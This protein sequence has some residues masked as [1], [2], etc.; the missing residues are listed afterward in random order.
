MKQKKRMY[1]STVTRCYTHPPHIPCVMSR[2][3]VARERL[4]HVARAARARTV[5]AAALALASTSKGSHAFL[6]TAATC[7]RMAPTICSAPIPADAV[8]W[9]H[10]PATGFYKNGMASVARVRGL[11]NV[12]RHEVIVEVTVTHAD[13]TVHGVPHVRCWLP[14]RDGLELVYTVTAYAAMR[15][16]VNLRARDAHL[17]CAFE[18]IPPVTRMWSE[19]P[20]MSD[21][22]F[23]TDR[24]AVCLLDIRWTFHRLDTPGEVLMRL[25]PC[26]VWLTKL[27]FHR[28]GPS[29]WWMNNICL[30]QLWLLNV[31]TR[32]L[33]DVLP[34]RGDSPA[35]EFVTASNHVYWRNT[36]LHVADRG[37]GALLFTV[38][39]SM[40]G[41]LSP[42]GSFLRAHQNSTVVELNLHSGEVRHSPTEIP[43]LDGET[44]FHC[45]NGDFAVT[46]RDRNGC[47][48]FFTRKRDGAWQVHRAPVAD[49]SRGLV[50]NVSRGRVVIR[51]FDSPM[52]CLE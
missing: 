47:V 52:V 15:V 50:A 40:R 39:W 51:C 19:E 20:Q 16:R 1:T 6:H 18:P 38:P 27:T 22:M 14:D 24:H 2:T 35:A 41:A 8:R 36:I 7:E 11:A 45:P 9:E 17:S 10:A 37:S 49:A 21:V 4:A 30:M 26:Q 23:V 5:Q 12:A 29:E 28:C 46:A 42:D 3:P 33:E 44:P 32:T 48:M 43:A 31:E 25:D 13:G 34:M